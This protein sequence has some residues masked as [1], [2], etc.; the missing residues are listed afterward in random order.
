[1]KQIFPNSP[2]IYSTMNL[3]KRQKS[4][5]IGVTSASRRRMEMFSKI[6]GP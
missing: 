6:L 3:K 2:E 1:M 5:D 4:P